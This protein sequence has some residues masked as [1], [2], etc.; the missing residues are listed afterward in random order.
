MHTRS[1]H[2][3]VWLFHV[4][5]AM[6]IYIGLNRWPYDGYQIIRKMTHVFFLVTLLSVIPILGISS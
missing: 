5:T 6:V 1:L 4:F 2:L 3:L